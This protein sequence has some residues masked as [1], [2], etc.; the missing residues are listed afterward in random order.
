MDEIIVEAYKVGTAN[1]AIDFQQLNVFPADSAA[2]NNKINLDYILRKAVDSCPR[3]SPPTNMSMLPKSTTAPTCLPHR[4]KNPCHTLYRCSFC[5]NITASS[6]SWQGDLLRLLPTQ[7]R[8]NPHRLP[9]RLIWPN[10]QNRLHPMP[11]LL[12]LRHLHMLVLRQPFGESLT[13]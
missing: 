2:A 11:R 12:V 10:L 13:L 1:L 4:R 7:P 8:R 5:H 3:T 6:F 9:P